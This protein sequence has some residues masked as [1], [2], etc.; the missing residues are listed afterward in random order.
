M[1]SNFGVSVPQELMQFRKT[2]ASQTTKLETLQNYDYGV[3]IV[4]ND[5]GEI[6][7]V[8][9][10]SD[11]NELQ[12]Q[13]CYSASEIS[14]IKYYSNGRIVSLEEYKEGRVLSKLKYNKA[15]FVISRLDYEYNRSGYITKIKK[16]KNDNFCSVEYTYDD[17]K[18]INS[19]KVS[20]GTEVILYQKY[21]YDILGRI[22]EYSDDNQ[23]ISIHKMGTK[24]ELISYT[25]IDKIGN[26]T[27]VNNHY[28]GSEY[29]RTDV[30]LN[31]HVLSIKDSS[32]VDN[33]MLKKPYTTED[34]LDLIISNLFRATAENCT[35]RK[36][37]EECSSDMVSDNIQSRVLPIS[38]RKRLLYNIAVQV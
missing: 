38:I 7:S 32:Y 34:D 14:S 29:I 10:Y 27:S 31:G 33:V 11:D 23:T 37:A 20:V 2:Y 16:K 19:R 22:V 13:V 5:K 8:L 12:K 17:F 6:D 24:N 3:K 36:T 18:N 4:K 9:Y 28:A 26:K 15:C 25:I 1:R 21:R 30:S 35:K